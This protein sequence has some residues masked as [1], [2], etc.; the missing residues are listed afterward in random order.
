VS[1]P[2]GASS[3]NGGETAGREMAAYRRQYNLVLGHLL[4]HPGFRQVWP[5]RNTDACA[6]LSQHT[7]L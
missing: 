7:V 2:T 1:V 3:L 5:S 4:R 6:G